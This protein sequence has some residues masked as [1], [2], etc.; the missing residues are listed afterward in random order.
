MQPKNI[1]DWIDR[2]INGQLNE[3]EKKS[4]EDQM[5]NDSELAKEVALQKEIAEAMSEKDVLELSNTIR[6][7]IHHKAADKPGFQVFQLRRVFHVAATIALIAI[8]YFL[9]QQYLLN[10]SPDRL[11]A[12]YTEYDSEL[13]SSF[14]EVA[15]STNDTLSAELQVIRDSLTKLWE[16]ANNFYKLQEY[17]NTISVMQSISQLDPTFDQQSPSEF[18]YYM[19]IN[20]MAVADFQKAIDNFQQVTRAYTEKSAWYSALCYLYLNEPEAAQKVL[21]EILQ[22]E[23]HPYFEKATELK[24]RLD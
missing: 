13:Y 18:H 16:T 20:Q 1:Q 2:Y 9:F 21:T 23:S 5:A 17:H 6:T 3:E 14:L 22:S 15:R 4:F 8:C 10:P 12:Q 19:G 11:A 24:A 7:V